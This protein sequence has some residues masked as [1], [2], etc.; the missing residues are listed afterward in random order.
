[1]SRTPWIGGVVETCVHGKDPKPLDGGH[2]GRG[3]MWLGGVL[4]FGLPLPWGTQ[5]GRWRWWLRVLVVR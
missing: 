1:M 5:P 2:E 3:T 4:G